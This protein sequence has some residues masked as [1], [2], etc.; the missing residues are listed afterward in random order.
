M[1]S[2]P[3]P[4]RKWCPVCG[5]RKGG[6]DSWNGVACKCGHSIDFQRILA[7]AAKRKQAKDAAKPYVQRMIE[8]GR[9]FVCT[10]HV[11]KCVCEP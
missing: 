1:P 11:E 4:E 10:M 7:E 9:C 5:W 3:Y 2:D 6:E 8:N